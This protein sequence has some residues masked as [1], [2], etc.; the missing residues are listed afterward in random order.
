MPHSHVSGW[1]YSS[2]TCAFLLVT[3]GLGTWIHKTNE[4]IFFPKKTG[5]KIKRNLHQAQQQP[6]EDTATWAQQG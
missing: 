1:L 3:G 2:I 6:L 5:I 4:K